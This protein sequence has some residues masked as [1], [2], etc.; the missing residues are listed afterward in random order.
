MQGVVHRRIVPVDKCGD[1]VHDPPEGGNQD[2]EDQKSNDT[3]VSGSLS[4]CKT[5]EVSG[6]NIFIIGFPFLPDTGMGHCAQ[7]KKVQACQGNQPGKIPDRGHQLQEEVG[8]Q[9]RNR[10]S[11]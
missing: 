3:H 7:K 1:I 4:G 6:N 10:H 2:D 9:L 8:G 11:Q 5:H